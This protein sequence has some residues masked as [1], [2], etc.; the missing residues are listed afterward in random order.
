MSILSDAEPCW[1]EAYGGD[2]SADSS[3][4]DPICGRKWFEQK[5]VSVVQKVLGTA[6]DGE[7]AGVDSLCSAGWLRAGLRAGCNS[8]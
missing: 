7:N 1:G 5:C 2:S 8:R 3:A 6:P 4:K